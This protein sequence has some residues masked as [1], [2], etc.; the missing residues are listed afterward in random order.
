MFM[1]IWRGWL[2]GC[3]KLFNLSARQ[4][5]LL[6][7]ALLVVTV[8]IS[9]AVMLQTGLPAYARTKPWHWF[10]ACLAMGAIWSAVMM[11]MLAKFVSWWK[12]NG[13]GG[14]QR[15]RALWQLIKKIR[16][17]RWW[18]SGTVAL[19]DFLEGHRIRYVLAVMASFG[20]YFTPTITLRGD[21]LARMFYDSSSIIFIGFILF[22]LIGVLK[23]FVSR[24]RGIP[25]VLC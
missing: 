9:L 10:S 15:M 4:V 5:V 24:A 6:I 22:P 25:H 3:C 2:D 16:Y 1:K 11:P 20:W 8:A 17:I 13:P 7:L 23:E 18:I 12:Q 21:R 14:G 19:E